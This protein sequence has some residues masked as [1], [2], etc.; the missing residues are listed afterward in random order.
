MCLGDALRCVIPTVADCEGRVCV[1][2][3][4]AAVIVALPAPRSK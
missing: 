1:I 4:A 2:V 3:V